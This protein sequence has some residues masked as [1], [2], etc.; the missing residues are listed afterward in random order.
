[1]P[2]SHRDTGKASK[3]SD[4]GGTAPQ[5]SIPFSI[6]ISSS[7]QLSTLVLVLSEVQR[8]PR[9][10]KPVTVLAERD[11]ISEVVALEL[12]DVEITNVPEHH[13]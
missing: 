9:V 2:I 6:L 12:A 1:M 4:E 11:V 7:A 10:Q 13:R 3:L 5:D 8:D